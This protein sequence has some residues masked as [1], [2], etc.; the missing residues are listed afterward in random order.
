MLNIS[1][2]TKM[3]GNARISNFLTDEAGCLDF[4]ILLPPKFKESIYS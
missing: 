1:L 3:R 4:S 2:L